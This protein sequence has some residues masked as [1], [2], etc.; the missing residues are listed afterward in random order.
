MIELEPINKEI[1]EKHKPEWYGAYIYPTDLSISLDDKVEWAQNMKKNWK[2]LYPE[3]ATEYK[4][5][6]ILYYHLNH[7]HCYLVKRDRKWFRETL[8]RFKEFWD[9]VLEYRN[10]P[11]KKQELIDEMAK[12]VKD[13]ELE[14]LM[15]IEEENKKRMSVN[16]MDSDED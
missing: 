6:K 1:P 14:R 9:Q 2:T 13:E 16:D 10:D 4:F 7:S 11:I 3:Y 15:K 8:P 12:K 5:G